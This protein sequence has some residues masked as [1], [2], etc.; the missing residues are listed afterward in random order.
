MLKNIK[1]VS[2]K[3]LYLSK[4]TEINKKKIRLLLSVILSNIVV[5]IDVFVIVIFTSLIGDYVNI[6]N[7]IVSTILDIF[8]NYK[9]LF[10]LLIILRYILLFI[11][12]YNVELLSLQVNEKLKSR[13]ITTIFTRG[14]YS[15]ADSYF[16]INGVSGHISTFYRTSANLL[17]NLVQIIGYS[18]FLITLNS[19]AF[20]IFMGALVVLSFPTKFLLSKAKYYQHINF[21]ILKDLNRYI[22]R[23]VDNMFLIK[24]LNTFQNESLAF[25]SLLNKY[26]KAAAQNVIF[27]S[28][29]AI[30]P[31]FLTAFILA[32]MLTFFGF[33]K[34]ITLEFIGVLLRIFQSLGNLNNSL[35]MVI[36]SSVHIEDLY[37]F[38]NQKQIRTSEFRNINNNAKDSVSFRD[39]SFTY[40]RSSEQIFSDLNLN[41]EKN[42]HTIITGPNGSGKSTLLGLISGLY[43]PEK[44]NIE[45]FSKKLGYVGV[46]PLIIET[47][48]RENLLYGNMSEVKDSY[49]IELLERFKFKDRLVDLDEVVS[50]KTL[51]SGQ[52]QK[53]SFIRA[54]LNNVDI[55]LLDESTSNLDSESKKLI[56]EILNNENITVINSTHNKEDFSYD[57]HI[58]ITVEKGNRY[59][60]K[61]K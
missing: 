53:V 24:I 44:G 43:V 14:N 7:I 51:S 37:E 59:L 23:V 50:N 3:I 55:L 52:M 28:L 4:L 18:F 58:E 34:F 10:P 9:I 42:S 35:A 48:I 17:N 12:R 47:S 32:I 8:L 27:G 22:Q 30:L 31:T 40:L 41:I 60:N 61:I 6:E 33:A 54:L 38:E 39:V 15:I 21:T 25:K 2:S 36:N 49:I 45:V 1:Q 19:Y 16:Y 26:K 56:F 13:I 11:E 5:A 57:S 20:F 46:T 29:N